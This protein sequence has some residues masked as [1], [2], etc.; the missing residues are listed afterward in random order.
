MSEF[1][2]L[3]CFMCGVTTRIPKHEVERGAA[4]VEVDCPDC[5]PS[6]YAGRNKAGEIRYLDAG[7]QEIYRAF[8]FVSDFESLWP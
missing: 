7:G 6:G 2:T 4:I 1:A 5:D 8:C 3:R